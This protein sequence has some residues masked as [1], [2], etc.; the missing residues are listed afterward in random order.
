MVQDESSRSAGLIPFD[1]PVARCWKVCRIFVT[2]SADWAD[3][4]DHF[5]S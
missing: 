1:K 3:F 5:G 2:Y 4:S